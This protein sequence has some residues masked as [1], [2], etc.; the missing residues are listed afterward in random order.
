MLSDP[1]PPDP[2]DVERALARRG[3]PEP[4]A[5]LRGRILAALSAQRDAAL[6]PLRR[7]RWSLVWQ[8]AAALVVAANLWLSV[9]TTVRLGRLQSPAG[10]EDKMSSR[11]APSG[12]PDTT[13]GDDPLQQLAARVLANLSPAP[14]AGALGR[15]FFSNEEDR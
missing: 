4:S 12:V 9:T 7:N 6:R 5:D 1:L 14:P 2:S 3:C 8:A 13:D 10:G 11:M 15:N